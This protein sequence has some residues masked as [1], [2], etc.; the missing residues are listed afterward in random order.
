MI[1]PDATHRPCPPPAPSGT[2]IR[3]IVDE[4]RQIAEQAIARSSA[5]RDA[6]EERARALVER[7]RW[8]V[9]LRQT[10]RGLREPMEVGDS[11]G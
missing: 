2:R 8:L 4:A 7:E 3:S 10:W 9:R 11:H 5:G 1:R 6:R